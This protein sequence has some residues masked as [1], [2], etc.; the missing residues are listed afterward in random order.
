MKTGMVYWLKK[1]FILVFVVA[2]LAILNGTPAN[3]SPMDMMENCGAPTDDCCDPAVFDH[4]TSCVTCVGYIRQPIRPLER[5]NVQMHWNIAPA[6]LSPII[7][8]ID[9]PPPR[10]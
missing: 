9:P 2:Q 7:W 8:S 4:C 3:A 6:M 5:T 1:L 10:Y